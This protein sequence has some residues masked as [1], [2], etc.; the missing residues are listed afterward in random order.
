MRIEFLDPA[1]QEFAEAIAFYNEQSEGLGFRFALE[2]K[3][4]LSRILQHPN[5]WNPISKRTRRCRTDGFP[6]GVIYQVRK[7]SILIVA[8]SH[9]HRHP[10]HWK[11]R[12]NSI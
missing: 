2:I 4:T 8:V 10:E 1:K 9:L 11:R 6:F 3:R 7:D 5:A 12:L